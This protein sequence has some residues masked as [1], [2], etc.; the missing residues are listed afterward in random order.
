MGQFLFDFQIFGTEFVKKR[1]KRA[2]RGEF[3]EYHVFGG[4]LLNFIF[5][6][7]PIDIANA[8]LNDLVLNI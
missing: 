6:W 3:I 4:G 8:L 7:L 2:L 1:K 5:K